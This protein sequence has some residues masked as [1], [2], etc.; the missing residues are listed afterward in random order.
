MMLAAIALVSLALLVFLAGKLRAGY[1]AALFCIVWYVVTF[2]PMLPLRDHETE[3]YPYIPVIG[4]AWLG[5]WG[6][7]EAWRRGGRVTLGWGRAR[8]ALYCAG[9]AAN[10]TSRQH[11]ITA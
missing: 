7:I 6:L 8:R 3:Y 11:G 9:F 5:A 4:L 2:V 1:Q 10:R